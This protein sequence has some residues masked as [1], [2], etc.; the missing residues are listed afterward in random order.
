MTN[1]FTVNGDKTVG[2][3]R[4]TFFLDMCG[5]EEVFLRQMSLNFTIS[6][7]AGEGILR[8]ALFFIYCVMIRK[9]VWNIIPLERWT[10]IS[11]L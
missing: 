10:F 1:L 6:I 3:Y 11:F 7:G 9:K 8:G 2:V 5:V 4:G